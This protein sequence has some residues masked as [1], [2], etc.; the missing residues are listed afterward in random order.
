MTTEEL[1]VLL[2]RKM[3]KEME[4]FKDELRAS[5]PD[6]IMGK[7]YEL[8]IKEDILYHLEYTDLTDE[9]AK[10]LLKD[11]K[12]LDSIYQKWEHM[13]NHYMD[14]ISDAVEARANDL[15]QMRKRDQPEIG[16]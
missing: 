1:N 13:D 6:E 5:T 9:R 14:L 11:K 4:A 7:A 15:I 12:P 8:A 10:A 3:E 16:R 2:Y